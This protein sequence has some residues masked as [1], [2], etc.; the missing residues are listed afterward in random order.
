MFTLVDSF[1]KETKMKKVAIFGW[2]NENSALATRRFDLKEEARVKIAQSTPLYQ[3]WGNSGSPTYSVDVDRLGNIIDERLLLFDAT[4]L[5]YTYE[6][7]NDEFWEAI[8]K[9]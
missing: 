4:E 7:S 8:E 2:F 1:L 9:L 5:A 3:L 6:M